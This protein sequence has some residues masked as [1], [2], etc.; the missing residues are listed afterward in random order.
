[1]IF[2]VKPDIAKKKVVENDPQKLKQVFDREE[3]YEINR[4]FTD[5]PFPSHFICEEEPEQL[6][7]ELF[8]GGSV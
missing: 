4:G 1:M 8:K 7:A 2:N 3:M 6:V 5:N